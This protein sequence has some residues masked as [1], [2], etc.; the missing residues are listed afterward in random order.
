MFSYR[1]HMGQHSSYLHFCAVKGTGLLKSLFKSILQFSWRDPKDPQCLND[2]A[3]GLFTA[4]LKR[5]QLVIQSQ[6]FMSSIEKIKS[7]FIF[8]VITLF[9]YFDITDFYQAFCW[10]LSLLCQSSKSQVRTV[11]PSPVKQVREGSRKEL[12]TPGQGPFQS[13]LGHG[14]TE[15]HRAARSSGSFRAHL[16]RRPP[17]GT[18]QMKVS[19]GHTSQEPDMALHQLQVP[20]F[21]TLEAALITAVR[22]L[23]HSP[24]LQALT[25]KSRA[26]SSIYQLP[27]TGHRQIFTEGLLPALCHKS[28]GNKT[29]HTHSRPKSSSTVNEWSAKRNWSQGSESF[30][31]IWTWH[32]VRKLSWLSVTSFHTGNTVQ[33]SQPCHKYFYEV[34]GRH[35]H[36]ERTP[37]KRADAKEEQDGGNTRHR[38][39]NAPNSSDCRGQGHLEEVPTPQM[40]CCWKGSVLQWW[41]D[42]K[43][44]TSTHE[45]SPGATA[46]AQG[47]SASKLA[48]RPRGL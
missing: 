7:L 17:Q 8:R 45:A 26:W 12:G 32:Q 47:D 25:A 14:S 37:E 19:L 33:I 1:E 15:Q 5:I 34:V 46:A 21:G 30:G 6:C 41:A 11:V 31:G 2:K 18:E 44:G 10:V 13:V 36:W 9:W 40:C 43:G 42:V 24:Q 20:A 22:Q 38:T 4:I 28:M 27:S 35:E 48:Q 39:L 29:A 23:S 3:S 16:G